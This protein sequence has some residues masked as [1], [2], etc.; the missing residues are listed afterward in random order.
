MLMISHKSFHLYSI[1]TV[2]IN[3]AWYIIF[4]SDIRIVLSSWPM[5]SAM[6]LRTHKNDVCDFPVV[7]YWLPHIIYSF[8][9]ISKHGNF[10]KEMGN[11]DSWVI[12]AWWHLYAGISLYMPSQWETMLQCNII[13][14]WLGAYTKLSLYMHLFCAESSPE[15][16]IWL[17]IESIEINSGA[18]WIKIQVFLYMKNVYKMTSIWYNLQSVKRHAH[19]HV[20][21]HGSN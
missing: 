21:S 3:F 19:I 2:S 6:F 17:A 14:H 12:E 11:H 7:S 5:I 10:S 8:F 9:F 16:M 1:F 20:W 13:P 4:I 18:V 15:P